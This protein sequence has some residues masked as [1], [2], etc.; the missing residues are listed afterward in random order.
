MSHC[1][2]EN[3]PRAILESARF[4]RHRQ[5]VA[6]NVSFNNLLSRFP[7]PADWREKYA[8]L[9]R[10][11]HQEEKPVVGEEEPPPAAPPPQPPSRK[12]TRQ[13]PHIPPKRPR[14]TRSSS[15]FTNTANIATRAARRRT[16]NL[17]TSTAADVSRKPKTTSCRSIPR[18]LLLQLNYYPEL[19]RRLQRHPQRRKEPARRSTGDMVDWLILICAKEG[20]RRKT[21]DVTKKKACLDR[22]VKRGRREKWRG[23]VG[24][25]DTQA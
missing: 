4:E 15:S 14:T 16:E 18:K 2:R 24:G 13:N 5:I 25:R 7:P 19:Q 8:L 23:G 20:R 3:D 11:L 1:L 9:E 10:A 17:A 22:N 12:G 6:I 21:W